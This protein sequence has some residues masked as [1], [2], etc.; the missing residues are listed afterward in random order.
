MDLN[1][2]A[3]IIKKKMLKD[4]KQT[5]NNQKRA[6]THQPRY[7]TNRQFPQFASRVVVPAEVAIICSFGIQRKVFARLQI[8]PTPAP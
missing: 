8:G 2:L 3:K 1:K 5:I 6:L 7:D 4:H